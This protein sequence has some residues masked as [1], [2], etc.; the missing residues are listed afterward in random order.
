MSESNK[1]EPREQHDEIADALRDHNLDL[2]AN[3]MNKIK[4]HHRFQSTI[5]RLMKLNQEVA[6]ARV[7]NGPTDDLFGRWKAALWTAGQAKNAHDEARG[8]REDE[9]QEFIGIRAM[10]KNPKGLL[11]P[12]NKPRFPEG[13]I[14]DGWLP[15]NALGIL[16]SP[17]ADGKTELALQVAYRLA[18][19][20][21]APLSK[22]RTKN[23]KPLNIAYVS[24]F[25]DPS[26]H[27]SHM[28]RIADPDDENPLCSPQIQIVDM[29]ETHEYGLN[30][31]IKGKLNILEADV[32]ILDISYQQY[33]TQHEFIHS[34]SEWADWAKMTS[35]SVLYIPRF[36]TAMDVTVGPETKANSRETPAFCWGITRDGA[37]YRLTADFS[38]SPDFNSISIYM[39]DSGDWHINKL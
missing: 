27:E 36:T 25:Y 18:T 30:M 3:L 38:G 6:E 35:T 2:A 23:T 32:A 33:W 10:M 4:T 11:V 19:G 39:D 9:A 13:W 28:K 24:N 16:A 21:S 5:K 8:E 14:I 15:K 22:Q 20:C 37:H 29:N 7:E 17:G 31:K 26:T 12:V 1:N 34:L